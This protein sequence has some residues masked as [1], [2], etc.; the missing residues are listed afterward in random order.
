MTSPPDPQVTDFAVAFRRFLDWV[1]SSA[2][3]G[4]GHEVSQ[5]VRD[6]LGTDGGHRSV[7]ARELPRFEH[8]NL[9]AAVN[10]WS[11]ADGR[12]VEVQ[13][14]A[15]PPHYGGLSLQQLVAGEGMPP[16]QLTAPALADLPNGPGSTL[17]CLRLALLLVTDSH[18]RYVVMI[19][20]PG[21]HQPNLS[22]EVAGLPVGQA[23]DLLAELDR[24]RSELNVYRG[25]LLE[26]TLEQMGGVSL[27]FASPQRLGRDDVVL[28]D[29]VLTRIER[30]ALGVAA[31][32]AALLAA[33]QHLKRGLLLYGPPGTGKTHSTRYLLGQMTGYTRLVL[34]GRALVAVGAITE[35]ARAL[36]PA[37]VVLEDVDLVAEERSRGPASS[38]VLFDLL[39]AMDG[40]APD[41]DLLFL[42]T[43]NRA[44]LL[45][46][47]LAARPG[48]VDVAVE[49]SLPDAP[50]RERLLTLYGRGVPLTL[51][52]DD[53]ATA[54]ERTD[55]TTASFLKEL[56][57]RSVLE[58][59]HEDPELHAVTGA[60][61]SRALDDLLDAA[62]GVTRTLLGVGVDPAD[63]PVGGALGGRGLP[64][65]PGRSSSATAPSRAD[66]VSE[67]RRRPPSPESGEDDG[68][69]AVAQDTVLAVPADG[70]GQH[71]PLDVGAAT[72]QVGH[73]VGVGGP[74]HVLLDDRAIVQI[75]GDVVGGGPDQLH[76]AFAG[77]GVGA[78]PDERGQERVVDVDDRD[79]DPGDEVARQDLHVAG[80]HDEVHVALQQPQ[81]LGF[82]GGLVRAG[83]RHVEER[84]PEAADLAGG[85][86]V[87]G[88]DHR[89]ADRQLTAAVPPQQVEQA[90]IVA[91]GEDGHPLR[92]RQ[93]PQPELQ[94]EP[95]RQRL[96]QLLFHLR[97]QGRQVLQPEHSALEERPALRVVGVLVQ[98][99]DV[100]PEPGQYRRHRGHDPRP[101]L[102]LHDQRRVVLRPGHISLPGP[103]KVQLNLAAGAVRANA[104]TA[105]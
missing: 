66:R 35:L 102:A 61:L 81:V 69:L 47:A 86:G 38:P 98:G 45:E 25:H 34:T 77:P 97:Q 74:D 90:V 40:A 71:G 28:P 63:L 70:A 53:V 46:P 33:G 26:V 43:T 11:A 51:T 37:V 7:V 95:G 91:G 9:Q 94:L 59:L 78:G 16:L 2:G 64:P 3:D 89:H 32:R 104:P 72:L 103:V 13:G 19:Q 36:L 30:H 57:R 14:I 99:D 48:R 44:D 84:H 58:A 8:V 52:A 83:R 56:I 18:G 55:G 42:L 92:H 93:V 101:V 41:A 96:G 75:L 79:V 6:H 21:E 20:G 15:L 62:Q 29:A 5:L 60:H 49:I 17:A 24:L 76:P 12:A 68:V 39:D 88:D 73:G 4:P 54:V 65:G 27:T 67:P 82:G 85:V 23:Q 105:R 1:Q 50:A 31:H 10:A 100:R 22:V 80:Q 87:V